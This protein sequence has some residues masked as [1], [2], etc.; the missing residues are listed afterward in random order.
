MSKRKAVAAVSE[1]NW[2]A[3][4]RLAR[5][6]AMDVIASDI[7][8]GTHIGFLPDVAKRYGISVP[9]L[10][11]AITFLQEDGIVVPREGR[12][13]GLVVAALPAETAVQAMYVFFSQVG[14]SIG[15][16]R[17]ARDMID[18]ALAERACRY[19]DAEMLAEV[20]RIFRESRQPDADRMQAIRQ[21]DK[22][23]L[24][25]ARQPVFALIFEVL[26]SLEAELADLAEFD[27]TEQLRLRS[28]C[29]RAIIGGNLADAITYRRLLQPFRDQ[30][31]GQ[32]R[33]GRL[34]DRVAAAIKSLIAERDLGPGDE[35]GREAELQELLGVGRITLRDAL[36]PL[37]R[38]GAIRVMPGRKGGIFVGAA[39]P[40]AAIEMISLYL[41]SI[42]LSFDAQ[43]ESRLVLEPKA[44]WLAAERRERELAERLASAAGEDRTAALTDAPGWQDKGAQVERLIARACGNPLIE[45]FTLALVEISLIQGRSQ[46]A[47]LEENRASFME[48]VS[49]HHGQIVDEI[50][51]RHPAR[52]A[53]ATRVY[54]H[55][56]HSWVSEATERYSPGIQRPVPASHLHSTS[57]T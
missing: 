13:G 45:F 21:F 53:F 18:V 20:E 38:S 57:K 32:R 37:E 7:P 2:P 39:E 1:R 50:V 46:A 12:G 3:P 36:R 6:I 44:A 30:F 28:S 52:A 35:L 54:L 24:H 33:S 26:G 41:S 48:L 14:V 9:T 16:V 19:A 40:Y 4:V 56:L 17:E 27:V 34:G 43:I 42:E 25:A 11:K 55:D 10:R 22:A 47:A 31:E 29:S 49:R 23:I 15:Q 5:T 8:V 51:A